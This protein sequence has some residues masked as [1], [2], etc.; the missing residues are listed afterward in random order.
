MSH[1]TLAIG[2]KGVQKTFQKFAENFHPSISGST[3]GRIR[4][5]YS[6][7]VRITG[8][9]VELQAGSIKLD[10]IDVLIDPLTLRLEV[11]IPSVT[12]GGFCIIPSP[13]GGC[14]L[15]APR[16]TF[17]SANPDIRIPINLSGLIQSE[18]SGAFRPEMRYKVDPGRTSTMSYLDAEDANLPDKWQLFLDPIWVDLDLIDIADTVGN[19]LDRAIRNAVDSLLGFL[20]GWARSLVL[21]IL[22]GLVSLIRRLLDIGDDILE[23]LSNLLGTSLGLFNTIVTLV[24]DYFA[25][26]TSLFEFE[27][28]YPILPYQGSLIP[29]KIPFQVVNADVTPDELIVS[30]DVNPIL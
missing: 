10:E 24:L 4:A 28:P 1:F 11:D 17:F 12:V 15:R 29:V 27:N 26:K 8:G 23:W 13:F 18:I 14:W 6:A 25:N 20:P 21:A 2:E 9:T 22:G 3:S 30:A 19:I 7:G 5:S 16:V